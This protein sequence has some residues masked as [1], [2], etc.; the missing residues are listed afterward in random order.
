MNAFAHQE[1]SILVATDI[2]ARG[3]DIEHVQYVYNHNI[4]P[5]PETYTH[6]IGRTGRAGKKGHSI[7]L[8]D[9]SEANSLVQIEVRTGTALI[10][11][12]E[13][14]WH[15]P[16]SFRQ[17]IIHRTELR[18]KKTSPKRSSKKRNQRPRRRR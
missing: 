5:T 10:D 8:C 18:Q 14:K 1:R 13:H 9:A 3:I 12:V 6:R 16:Q 2:A 11:D 15:C 7:S 4:P 17:T